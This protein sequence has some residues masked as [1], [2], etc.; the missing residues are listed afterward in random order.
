MCGSQILFAVTHNAYSHGF[1]SLFHLLKQVTCI[2]EGIAF[3]AQVEGQWARARYFAA[4]SVELVKL[5]TH[6]TLYT[7]GTERMNSLLRCPSVV[8]QMDPP[9]PL[10]IVLWFCNLVLLRNRRNVRTTPYESLGID[11]KNGGFQTFQSHLA[12]ETNL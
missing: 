12:G 2:Q 9:L 6:V 7:K 8:R 4:W 10:T 5:N 11:T 1:F 3:V